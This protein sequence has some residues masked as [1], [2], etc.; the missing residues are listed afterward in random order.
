M[1]NKS[2][3]AIQKGGKSIG[4]IQAP[5]PSAGGIIPLVVHHM[6]QTRS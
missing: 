1:S 4:A 3:G 2:I 5:V 6:N